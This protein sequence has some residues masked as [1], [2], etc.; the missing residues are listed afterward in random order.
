MSAPVHLDKR[1]WLLTRML[2]LFIGTLNPINRTDSGRL[3]SLQLRIGPPPA[4][5]TSTSPG[6]GQGQ[7]PAAGV[8]C[9][10]SCNFSHCGR[11]LV[12]GGNDCIAYVWH[13]NIS[14]FADPVDGA[15]AEADVPSTSA[16]VQVC[17]LPPF[18]AAKT[19]QITKAWLLPILVFLFM[20]LAIH[21]K[22]HIIH[23]CSCCNSCVLVGSLS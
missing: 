6:Q 2:P 14:A 22:Y 4:T 11:F 1:A 15:P 16:A 23:I 9:L 13:W 21:D 18:Y 19:H 17:D 20:W 12:A 8:V 3:G 10:M 5:T 7:A